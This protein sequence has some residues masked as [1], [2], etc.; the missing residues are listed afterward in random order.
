MGIEV[1][2]RIESMLHILSKMRDRAFQMHDS[3]DVMFLRARSCSTDYIDVEAQK[4]RSLHL[5]QHWQVQ[6]YILMTSRITSVSVVPEDMTGHRPAN[7]HE[8][9]LIS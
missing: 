1:L 2:I 4:A 7:D 8:L 9:T 5:V 3:G 6:I